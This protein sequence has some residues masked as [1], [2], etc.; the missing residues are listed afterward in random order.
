MM[1]FVQP[2]FWILSGGGIQV[3]YSTSGPSLH[4]QDSIRSLNFSGSEIRVVDVPD[5]GTLVSVTIFLTVDTGSASFT[6]LLPTVNLA[7]TIGSSAPVSTEGISTSH[8]FSIFAGFDKNQQEFY[9][10]TALTGTGFNF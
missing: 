10:V 9:G 8:H 1:S 6:L 5:L 4:Y 7:P 3:T 2:N